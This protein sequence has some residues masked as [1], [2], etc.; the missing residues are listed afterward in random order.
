MLNFRFLQGDANGDGRVN[1]NDFNILAANFGQGPRDFT[2][3]D[4]N[5]SGTVNLSD[6]NILAARF[7][8]VLAAPR[9][10]MRRESQR[11]GDREMEDDLAGVLA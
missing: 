4:F 9:I 2:Q 11:V 10:P 7:G 8:Q 3:G 6:F 5:Y 1:L